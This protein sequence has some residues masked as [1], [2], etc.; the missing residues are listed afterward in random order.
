MLGPS[1]VASAADEGIAEP[2]TQLHSPAS[3]APAAIVKDN[4]S[5]QLQGPEK[6]LH[7]WSPGWQKQHG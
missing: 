3:Q 5:W 7:C 1:L 4:A 2:W 6:D